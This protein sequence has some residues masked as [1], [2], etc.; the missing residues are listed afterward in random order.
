MFPTHQE[1]FISSD[2]GCGSI[3]RRWHGGHRLPLVLL[4]L[5]NPDQ[6]LRRRVDSHPSQ[7]V[8]LSICRETRAMRWVSQ[9]FKRAHC[10]IYSRLESNLTAVVRLIWGEWRRTVANT[11]PNNQTKWCIAVPF[12]VAICA[13]A[14]RSS[15]CLIRLQS[16]GQF[17]I[18]MPVSGKLPVDPRATF[19]TR[20][21]ESIPNCCS[22]IRIYR[23]ATEKEES[24]EQANTALLQ[25]QWQE[26]EREARGE[27]KG[28][29]GTRRRGN[30]VL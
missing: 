10:N 13:A 21:L 20:T 4:R 3:T 30:A 15:I 16:S 8:H 12:N 5:I 9:A 18:F 14:F 26:G 17:A 24:A 23:G 1:D 19:P 28:G 29:G 11:S 22:V 27:Q 25:K 6:G 2:E 7:R